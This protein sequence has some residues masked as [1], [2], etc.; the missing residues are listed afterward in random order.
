MEHSKET[1]TKQKYLKFGYTAGALSKRKTLARAC[2][3]TERLAIKKK[4]LA[5]EA[6]RISKLTSNAAEE[7]QGWAVLTK[8]Q[9]LMK[10][11]GRKPLIN[12]EYLALFIV[13]LS[14]VEY[15]P[16]SIRMTVFNLK[17][18]YLKRRLHP[19]TK[20]QLHT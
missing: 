12:A 20:P 19:T 2:V 14:L 10:I 5:E 11:E 3:R 4:N 1:V 7:R 6:A 17:Y 15:S 16:A 9:K 13:H 8:F 18:T